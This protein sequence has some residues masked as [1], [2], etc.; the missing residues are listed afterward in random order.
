MSA[1]IVNSEELLI[2]KLTFQV[3]MEDKHEQH[4]FWLTDWKR[5]RV[6]THFVYV[7]SCA[8]MSKQE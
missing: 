8:V 2:F 4:N 5:N 1:W 6:Y 3:K 7:G